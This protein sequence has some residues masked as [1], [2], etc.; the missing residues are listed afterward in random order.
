MNVHGTAYRTIRVAADGWAVEIID[1][2]ALPHRFQLMRLETMEQVAHAIRTMQVRGAPLIGAAAAYGMALAARQDASDS[3]VAQAGESLC[4]TRPTAVNL[5]WA[6]GRV[7]ALLRELPVGERARAAYTAA[8]EIAENDVETCRKIGEHGLAVIREIAERKPGRPVEILTHCNAGWLATVDYG[9]ALSPVYH[10]FDRGIP[11]HVWVDETRPRNQGAGLTAWE[12]GAH[13][14]SHTIIVDSA[15]AH[16][17]QR[18][19]VDL[20]ITGT[21]RTTVTGDVC[22]K[23]GT[24]SKALAASRSG[25]P[26]YVA[27]PHS[28]IDW[29]I[30]DGV[31]DIPIEERAMTEV[32]HVT[33]CTADGD[34]ETVQVGS[35]D[36]P[37]LNIAFDVT[38][39]D[40]V[41]ALI[42]ER[43]ICPASEAGLLSLYPERATVSRSP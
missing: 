19:R 43:G 7:S 31:A 11:V 29:T 32:T 22:N 33:G 36:S 30:R 8:G 2:T 24:Y 23:I 40:L 28:S 25:I 42:T 27:V 5:A 34:L 9:T 17:M 38:P 3:A 13:G 21:D 20:C 26:F 10:A 14:V 39:R 18:G 1:Q 12:L 37:A 16:L 41:T 6:V 15:A 4:R 35:P